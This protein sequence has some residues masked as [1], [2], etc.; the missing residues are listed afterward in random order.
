LKVAE[1]V[2][3]VPSRVL[4]GSVLGVRGKL[5]AAFVTS[6]LLVLFHALL[7]IVVSPIVIEQA[8]AG[9]LMSATNATPGCVG[10][11]VAETLVVLTAVK[12]QV[13]NVTTVAG[14]PRDEQP[15]NATGLVGVIVLATDGVAE[16]ARR[17]VVPVVQ[18]TVAPEGSVTSVPVPTCDPCSVVLSGAQLAADADDA[19]TDAISATPHTTYRKPFITTSRST[20]S[21]KSM[22]RHAECTRTRRQR[23]NRRP[24]TRP[25]LD[26]SKNRPPEAR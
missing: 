6:V 23:A 5:D 18:V 11:A 9:M 26:P 2:P 4:H 25:T 19:P 8:T 15:L 7:A 21:I 14:K 22:S 1:R 17:S 16:V 13:P 10:T 3:E 20:T 12:L 24:P